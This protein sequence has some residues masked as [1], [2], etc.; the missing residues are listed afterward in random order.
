[1]ERVRLEAPAPV[2]SSS[3]LPWWAISG[4]WERRGQEP[5]PLSPRPQEE[6]PPTIHKGLGAVVFEARGESFLPLHLP[7]RDLKPQ[8]IGATSI[9]R[10]AP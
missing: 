9:S 4:P 6:V 2:G 7:L 10:W 8:I 5:A 1:M 3:Q